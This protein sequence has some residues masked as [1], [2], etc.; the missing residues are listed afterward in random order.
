VFVPKGYTPLTRAIDCLARAHR[1]GRPYPSTT[2]PPPLSQRK[3]LEPIKAAQ[4]Q[5][6]VELQSGSIRAVVIWPVSGRM[7][8]IIPDNWAREAATTWIEQGELLMSSDSG[9]QLV[10]VSL[11]GVFPTSECVQ[12]FVS[13]DDLLRLMADVKAREKDKGGRPQ[14]HN[15]DAVKVYALAMIREHGLPGRGNRKFPSKT[16]LVEDISNKWAFQGLTL[17]ESTVRRYVSRWLKEL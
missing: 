1:A 15:W 8:E 14:D 13:I 10:G 17:A 5:L 2:P 4:E 9:M 6:R 12:I 11:G 3:N 16:Q 7:L